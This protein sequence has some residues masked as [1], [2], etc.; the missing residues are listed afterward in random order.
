M[1]IVASWASWA[2]GTQIKP[3]PRLTENCALDIP[4]INARFALDTVSLDLVVPMFGDPTDNLKLN[5][6]GMNT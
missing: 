3:L 1:E 4:G 5:Q 2:I 6:F